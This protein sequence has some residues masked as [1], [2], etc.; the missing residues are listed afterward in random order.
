MKVGIIGAGNMGAAIIH[1]L[2]ENNIVTEDNLLV[3]RKNANQGIKGFPDLHISADARQ[4]V[5]EAETVILAVKPQQAQSVFD[6]CYDAFENRFILSIMA[7][8]DFERIKSATPKSTRILCVMPNLPLQVGEGITLFSNK[9]NC[10]EKEL[11]F[12][13]MLFKKVGT[14]IGVDDSYF[15]SANALSGCAPAFVSLFIEALA[16]GAVRYGTP[17]AKA[18]DLAAQMII[19]TAKLIQQKG[20]HPAVLKDAVCSPNGI[21]IAG[22]QSL[23]KEGFRGAVIN[24]VEACVI[25]SKEL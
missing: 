4:V 11:A 22:I 7:G 17:R 25:K 15:A 13:E 14:V 5:H 1:A 12:A 10:T 3:C 16:D 23:E 2:L 8:W 18:Y 21:T 6:M 20:M 19:G 24:A 9:N